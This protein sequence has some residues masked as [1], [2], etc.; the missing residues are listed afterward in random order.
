MRNKVLTCVAACFYYSGLVALLRWWIQLSGKH[1]IILNYHRAS[2]G[3]LERHLRYLKDHYRI[4]D[5]EK[6]LEELYG[7]EEQEVEKK[8]RR[9]LLALTFDDGYYDNYSYAFLL[10]KQLGVPMAVYLVPGYIGRRER[11]WWQEGRALVARTGKREV[12][13]EEQS[14]DLRKER[15]REDL[16]HCINAKL[17]FASSVI[18]REKILCEIRKLLEVEKEVTTG[19]QGGLPLG[20]EEIKEMEESGW[21]TFGAH[22]MNHPILSRLNDLGELQ[23]EVEECRN[24]LEEKLGHP[25][26]TF[27]Y[28]IGQ[29]QHI[30]SGALHAVQKAG[31]RWGLTT[32]YGINTAREYPYLLKRIE[33]D[34]SQHWLIVAAEAVGLWGLVAR[35]R[36][37]PFIRQKWTNAPSAR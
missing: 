31:Y 17:R 20:W 12:R 22:S 7:Q 4:V 14:F 26:K 11:F 1:L 19:E 25:L 23:Y 8:D 33:T 27:A 37:H 34:V 21:I 2:G 32:S 5:L 24:I 35:L 10:A 18:E 15:E 13:Y 16:A 28:P 6:G 9:T 29:W 3:G 36:W 30:E